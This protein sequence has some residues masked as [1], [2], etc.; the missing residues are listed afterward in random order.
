MD[1]LG[2]VRSVKIEA[3]RQ[4]QPIPELGLGAFGLIGLAL[5]WT[6]ALASTRRDRRLGGV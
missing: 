3:N 2:Y 1:G 5:A 4:A 6:V